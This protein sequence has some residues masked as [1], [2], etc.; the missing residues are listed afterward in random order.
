MYRRYA[1]GREWSFEIL[2]LQPGDH[3]GV[4]TVIVELE[5]EGAWSELGYEGGT[6]QVKRVPA[7]EASVAGTRFTWWV[8][9]S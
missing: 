7:T 5:G 8:P 6:H 9:P 2:D 4:K 1:A 3:G